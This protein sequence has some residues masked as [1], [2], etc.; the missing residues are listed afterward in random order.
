[1]VYLTTSNACLGLA[2]E[3]MGLLARCLE[4]AFFS[5]QYSDPF[6]VDKF[7]AVETSTNEQNKMERKA[8]I[9]MELGFEG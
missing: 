4:P 2:F 8:R 6:R 3:F 1:M 5:A 7:W 9:F